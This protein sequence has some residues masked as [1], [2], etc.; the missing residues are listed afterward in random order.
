MEKSSFVRYNP[1]VHEVM[2]HLLSELT[3]R[4]NRGQLVLTSLRRSE[5]QHDLYIPRYEVCA[6]AG[7]GKFSKRMLIVGCTF[8]EISS[9]PSIMFVSSMENVQKKND[10]DFVATEHLNEYSSVAETRRTKLQLE[11]GSASMSRRAFVAPQVQL[12]RKLSYKLGPF[13]FK[14]VGAGK[15]QCASSSMEN[16]QK[17]NDDDFVAFEHLNEYSS[18]AETRRT[19]LQSEVGS[20]SMSRSKYKRKRFTTRKRCLKGV[21]HANR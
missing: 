20:A 13:L 4:S 14:K 6:K 10:D 17:K 8:H 12:P 2:Q 15:D 16:V 19:K 21:V 5:L 1:S 11:V 9:P 7:L 18:V 3:G